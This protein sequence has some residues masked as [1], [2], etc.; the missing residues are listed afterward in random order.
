MG[1]CGAWEHYTSTV[2]LCF[3][4]LLPESCSELFWE[5]IALEG[6]ADLSGPPSLDG[7]EGGGLSVLRHRGTNRG[8]IPSTNIISSLGPCMPWN[9]G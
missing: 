9:Q 2:L 7:G 1:E 5:I 6:S 3:G 8:L 4:H